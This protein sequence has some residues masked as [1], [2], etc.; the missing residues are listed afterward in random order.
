MRARARASSNTLFRIEW[1]CRVPDS[2]GYLKGKPWEFVEQGP[3]SQGIHAWHSRTEQGPGSATL[4]TLFCDTLIK[5]G[6]SSWRQPGSS[7]GLRNRHRCPFLGSDW[8]WRAGLSTAGQLIHFCQ[9]TAWRWLYKRTCQGLE[10]HATI[11]MSS[12]PK[13]CTSPSPFPSGSVS[14]IISLNKTLSTRI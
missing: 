12:A 13:T 10:R 8:G 11:F 6:V 4:Q 1:Q 5:E 7:Y 9:A 3:T 2:S 14:F